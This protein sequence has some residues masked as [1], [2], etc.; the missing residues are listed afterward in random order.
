MVGL[1]KDLEGRRAAE[2]LKEAE[3]LIK[4][5]VRVVRNVTTNLKP[6]FLDEPDL[7]QG[8]T[9]LA[10]T[11]K[12][13]F[14]L[15]VS[16]AGEKSCEVRDEAVRTLL[17]NLIRELLFNIVKHAESSEATIKLNF[18]ENALEV[19]VADEGKGFTPNF[20]APTSGTGL[21]LIGA[22]KRLRL[23]GGTLD[24]T[25]SPG[26]GT[27]VTNTIPSATLVSGWQDEKTQN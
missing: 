17:F 6:R 10:K 19:S 7:C 23:F 11:M 2:K 25:S 14:N 3:D 15:N 13:R 9:W 4:Q 21:G 27:R 1:R 16:L 5:T 12:K 22:H 24:V 26:E 20:S 18:S 8:L